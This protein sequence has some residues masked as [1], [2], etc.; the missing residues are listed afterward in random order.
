MTLLTIIAMMSSWIGPKFDFWGGGGNSKNYA[1]NREKLENIYIFH[2]CWYI[3]IKF[4]TVVLHILNKDIIYGTKL[5]KS[6]N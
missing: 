5:K 1:Q 3:V 4:Y 6:K 2:I